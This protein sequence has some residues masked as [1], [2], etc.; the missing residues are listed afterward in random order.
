MELRV[1]INILRLV[2]KTNKLP[3]INSK[4]SFPNKGGSKYNSK[5]KP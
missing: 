1:R 5:N 4:Y 2:K 3:D